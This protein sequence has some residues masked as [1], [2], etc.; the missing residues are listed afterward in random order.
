MFP[1]PNP[2]PPFS[3]GKLETRNSEPGTIFLEIAW[4]WFFLA[5]AAAV[6]AGVTWAVGDAAGLRPHDVA[7]FRSGNLYG[8]VA[9]VAGLLRHYRQALESSLA[10]VAVALGGFWV[11]AG[12]VLRAT[13]RR[14]FF[15]LLVLR[16]AALAAGA[17]A[18][19][20]LV[21]IVEAAPASGGWSGPSFSFLAASGM[22]CGVLVYCC[23]RWIGLLLLALERA[24]SLDLETWTSV[25]PRLALIAAA[26]SILKWLAWAGLTLL[27]APLVA[28]SAMRH[29]AVPLLVAV[30]WA[31][32]LTCISGYFAARLRNRVGRSG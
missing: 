29:P 22:V 4:R 27:L 8:M 15:R 3:P 10:V 23:W 6:I 25:V 21:L 17:S 20:C 2:V 30:V 16:T 31:V 26:C 24:P 9:T 7:V 14:H 5:F 18:L 19:A 13:S 32:A 28:V 12:A 1:G 11:L